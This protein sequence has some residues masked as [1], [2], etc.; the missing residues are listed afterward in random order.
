MFIL[1]SYLIPNEKN[2]SHR[3]DHYILSLYLCTT[4]CNHGRRFE[5]II[6]CNMHPV[7]ADGQGIRL[8]LFY[9]RN[10]HASLFIKY[11][12]LLLIYHSNVL[13]GDF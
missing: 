3:L 8:I 11:N 7:F 4:I 2:P 10:Y 9:R 12:H 13:S 6:N 5:F 1:V